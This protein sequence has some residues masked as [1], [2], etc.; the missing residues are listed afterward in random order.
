MVHIYNGYK[1]RLEAFEDLVYMMFVAKVG[2][3]K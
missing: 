1:D 3:K 2:D